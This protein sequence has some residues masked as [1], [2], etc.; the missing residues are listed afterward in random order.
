MY[1]LD[2][3]PVAATIG[4]IVISYYYT[5]YVSARLHGYNYIHIL[6]YIIEY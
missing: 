3:R 4:N 1:K 5:E 2:T 6:D